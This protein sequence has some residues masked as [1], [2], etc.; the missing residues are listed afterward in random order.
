[1]I[2]CLRAHMRCLCLLRMRFCVAARRR[3]SLAMMA[4]AH[5]HHFVVGSSAAGAMRRGR[6]RT[7]FVLVLCVYQQRGSSSSAGSRQRMYTHTHTNARSAH[8]AKRMYCKYIDI[9]VLCCVL[10]RA[11]IY[12]ARTYDARE[13]QC[14]QQQPAH[15]CFARAPTNGA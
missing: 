8:R 9:C 11:C 2:C 7:M 6:R 4:F 5:V 14:A 12:F 13:Q 3:A 1:M 10:R 15:C